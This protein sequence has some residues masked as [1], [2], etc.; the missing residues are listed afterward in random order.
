MLKDKSSILFC[1]LFFIQKMFASC[2]FCDFT[3]FFSTIRK[4]IVRAAKTV[5]AETFLRKNLLLGA[6]PFIQNVSFV[7]WSNQIHGMCIKWHCS[8]CWLLLEQSATPGQGVILKEW[9]WFSY[10]LYLFMCV[11][12]LVAQNGTKLKMLIP[13]E[14]DFFHDLKN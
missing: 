11:V 8:F 1:C 10:P 6:V 2:N 13:I 5:A 9:Y 4:K 12:P 14:R 3:G 7:H